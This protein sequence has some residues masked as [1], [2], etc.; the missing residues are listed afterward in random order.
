MMML[1]G[2]LVE[3]ACAFLTGKGKMIKNTR[4]SDKIF[5]NVLEGSLS[6]LILVKMIFIIIASFN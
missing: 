3:I 5:F 4:K 2:E 6:R 1:L